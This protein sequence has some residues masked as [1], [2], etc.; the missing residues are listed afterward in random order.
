MRTPDPNPLGKLNKHSRGGRQ[1]PHTARKEMHIANAVFRPVSKG[2]G[3]GKIILE[4]FY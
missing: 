1:I 4:K 2:R 3:A